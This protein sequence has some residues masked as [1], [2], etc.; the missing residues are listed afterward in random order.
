M[1]KFDKVKMS[2]LVKVEEAGDTL[3]LVFQGDTRITISIKDENLVSD[4]S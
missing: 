2:E 1:S 4:I 3:V